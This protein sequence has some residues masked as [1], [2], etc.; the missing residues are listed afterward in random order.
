MNPLHLALFA[1]YLSA[2]DYYSA[3]T[4]GVRR[5]RIRKLRRKAVNAAP[6]V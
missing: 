4:A 5:R 2:D 6:P 3:S 1:S